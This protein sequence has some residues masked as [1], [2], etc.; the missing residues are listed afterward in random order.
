MQQ[1]I[2]LFKSRT[3]EVKISLL[4]CLLGVLRLV[5]ALIDD[6]FRPLV[7]A[8][9]ATDSSLLLIFILLFYLGFTKPK[10]K[11][12]HS[13]V[14]F[15]LIIFICFNFVEFAGV[16]GNA[17][18]NILTALLG[19]ACLFSGKWMYTL[20]FTLLGLSTI[21]QLIILFKN[22]LM[23]PYFLYSNDDYTDFIFSIICIIIIT[24]FLKRLA[25]HERNNL[26]IKIRELNNKVGLAKS[27][28]RRLIQNHQELEKARKA[29]EEEVTKRSLH[30]KQQNS[31]IERYIHYNTEELKKPLLH[32]LE[33]VDEYKENTVLYPL[34]KISA[35]ELKSVISKINSTLNSNDL[36]DRSK[37]K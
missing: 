32:L 23:Q 33:A 30:I 6:F 9:V 12:I 13:T 35:H 27:T 20:T 37:I 36:L 31:A 22:E 19:L 18:F 21:L 7:F 17:E 24:S 2:E 8:E 34:L 4:V 29:L 10:F 26:E 25:T 11:G 3:F 16:R 28:N 14:G 1:Y 5:A 15:T